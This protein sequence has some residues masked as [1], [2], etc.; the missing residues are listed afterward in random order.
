ML[1]HFDHVSAAYDDNTAVP[2]MT[3]S[4]RWIYCWASGRRA[5]SSIIQGVRIALVTLAWSSRGQISDGSAPRWLRDRSACPVFVKTAWGNGK[6]DKA[7]GNA[8]RENRIELTGS[9]EA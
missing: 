8:S 7:P 2:Y 6:D 9:Q 3:L 5:I 1:V 4:K